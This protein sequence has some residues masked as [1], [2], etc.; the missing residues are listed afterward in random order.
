MVAL[1]LPQRVDVLLE[2]VRAA[3]RLRG[4]PRGGPRVDLE[5]E[6]QEHLVEPYAARAGQPRGPGEEGTGCMRTLHGLGV[7]PRLVFER[8]D[9]LGLVVERGER[10]GQNLRRGLG[11]AVGL[12][13]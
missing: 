5:H 7:A 11:G 12:A 6:R 13:R 8:R 9:D 10:L 2:R 3:L 1:H 4:G